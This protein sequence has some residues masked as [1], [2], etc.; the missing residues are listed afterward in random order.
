MPIDMLP[1]LA[2]PALWI[3]WAI[4]WIAAARGVK[5]SRWRE[6]ARTRVLHA[7][8]LV[9]CAALLATP[10]WLPPVLAARFAPPG[11]WLPL[12]GTVMVAGGLGFTGWARRHLGR[13]WSG[14]VTVKDD[15]TLICTGPYRLVRHP[16]YSGLLLAFAGN[17][18]AIGEWRGV[19]AVAFGFLAFVLKLRIEEARMRETF[20]EYDRYTQQVAALIPGL[21]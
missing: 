6:P 8:P 11:L 10:R 13:N 17:A 16:I 5:Q 1:R 9:L 18:L 21:F 12:L 7:T 19:L 4:C 20:P 2:I 15:H 3:V 14:W